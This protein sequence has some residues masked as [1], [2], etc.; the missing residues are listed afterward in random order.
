MQIVNNK[1]TFI[2][3]QWILQNVSYK[4]IESTPLV[5]VGLYIALLL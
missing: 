4:D 1:N 2:S 3:H 5:H